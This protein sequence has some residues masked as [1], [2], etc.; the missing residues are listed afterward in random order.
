VIK[1]RPSGISRGFAFIDFPTVVHT[2]GLSST[3]PTRQSFAIMLTKIRVPPTGSCPQ[4][5]G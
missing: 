5:D 2:T 3:L 1:E 4:N